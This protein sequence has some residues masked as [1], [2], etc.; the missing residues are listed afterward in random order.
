MLALQEWGS[1]KNN[2]EFEVLGKRAAR[3]E[4]ERAHDRLVGRSGV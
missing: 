2:P 1:G 3:P 4:R